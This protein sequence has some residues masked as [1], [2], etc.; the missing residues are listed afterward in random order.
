MAAGLDRCL[1]LLQGKGHVFGSSEVHRKLVTGRCQGELSGTSLDLLALPVLLHRFSITDMQ[2]HK[3][4]RP[5]RAQ[6]KG[7]ESAQNMPFLTSEDLAAA[8]EEVWRKAALR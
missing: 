4:Q 1:R 2:I 5:V 8:L 7:K 3:R 6:D